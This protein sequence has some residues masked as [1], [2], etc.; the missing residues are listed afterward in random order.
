VSYK[1][2]M[3]KTDFS[4]Q[5]ILNKNW[6]CST[7]INV[8]VSMKTTI[9]MISS[10]ERVPLVFCPLRG[11]F[12]IPRP[13]GV[14]ADYTVERVLITNSSITPKLQQSDYFNHILGV[15]DLFHD[16][17]SMLWYLS[18]NQKLNI[19]N[20]NSWRFQLKTLKKGYIRKCQLSNSGSYVLLG[21]V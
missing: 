2:H 12:I 21:Q 5:Y 19:L 13:T 11:G 8:Q 4:K 3:F 7:V 1:V 9:Y 18:L 20:R 6:K 15:E 17:A 10:V 16:I 14:V